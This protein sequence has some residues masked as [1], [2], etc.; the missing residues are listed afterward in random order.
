MECY[1]FHA[2]GA[3]FYVTF[4]VV[5]WLLILV[6]EPAC[7][8]VT[9]SLNFCHHQKGLR[10]NAYVIMPTHIHAILFHAETSTPRRSSKSSPTFASLPDASSRISVPNTC[11]PASKVCWPN[12][13]AAIENGVSGSR[14][15]IRFRSKPKAFGKQK[16][17]TFPIIPCA[18]A[19]SAKPKTGGFRPRAFG[20]PGG[21][22]KMTCC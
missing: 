7:K 16:S 10:I 11:R 15:A 1:R 19:W 9:E 20:R 2:D 3:L 8:I 21:K 14:R 17:I 12:V 22:P 18:R 4:S 6:S 13:P 5:D